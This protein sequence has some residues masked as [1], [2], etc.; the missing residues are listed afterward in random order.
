MCQDP[1][2]CISL[3]EFM[4]KHATRWNCEGIVERLVNGKS[5]INLQVNI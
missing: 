1:V 5:T 3:D 2:P 4:Q